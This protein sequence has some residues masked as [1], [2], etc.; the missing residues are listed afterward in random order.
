MDVSLTSYRDDTN[1]IV[2]DL[3]VEGSDIKRLVV[4]RNGDGSITVRGK[5]NGEQFDESFKV[6]NRQYTGLEPESD[7]PMRRIH[8][9]LQ[10]LLNTIGFVIE[11]TN[12]NVSNGNDE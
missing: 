5:V 9:D 2:D 12:V 1:Q 6:T 7:H 8:Q 11:P 4:L 3:T 10:S